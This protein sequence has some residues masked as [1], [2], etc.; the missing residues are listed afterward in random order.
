M[1]EIILKA[2][3]RNE[4]PKNVRKEGFIPGV[5]NGPGAVSTSV[6][7]ADAAL[8]KII[9]KHGVNAKLWVELGTEK[10]FG[11]I[12]EVQRHP[13]EGTILHVVIQLVSQN[14]EIKMN[15][16]IVFHGQED[17]E[18]KMLQLNICKSDV[19]VSGKTVDIP[20]MVEVDVS[21]KAAGDSVTAS[22]L[23]LPTE[24]NILD[25]QQEVYAS[26]KA[27]RVA[28]VEEPAEEKTA[29]NEKTAE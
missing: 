3:E 26:I 21:G 5:L 22:D 19:E 13:V 10:K 8:K 23:H 7:F 28:P 11:F 14:Q 29:E 18:R 6:K 15:L 27:F 24:I 9:A 16:P 25:P 1:E 2:S 12:K 20:E 17:L 4:K